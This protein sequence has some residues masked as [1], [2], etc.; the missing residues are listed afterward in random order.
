MRRGLSRMPCSAIPNGARTQVLHDEVAGE[1]PEE[2]EVV[3]RHRVAPARRRARAGGI[4][5][6]KP[7]KPLK[8]RV[9]LLDEVVEGHAD[10]Q[11]DHDR[12]DALGAHREPA[13]ERRRTPSRS[14][15][16][17]TTASHHG[18]PRLMSVPLRA[19]RWRTCSRRCPPPSSGPATPCRRSRRGRSAR[20]R[21][22]RAPAPAPPIWKVKNGVRHPRID[23]HRQRA[24]AHGARRTRRR[25]PLQPAPLARTVRGD[26]P[27]GRAARRRR[28]PARPASAVRPAPAFMAFRH[29]AALTPRLPRMPCGRK[30]STSAMITKREHHAVGRRVGQAELLGHADQQRRRWPRPTTLPMPPTMTTT[31][32]A[33]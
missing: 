11:R 24:P 23:Q 14:R 22:A 21:S 12:V 13:D 7:W 19:R 17:R 30:A 1:R 4:T 8:M 10:G 26:G 18:Q 33:S 29:S 9:V 32:E 15:A 25:D 6:W 3:E 27:R 2:R 5:L 16:R 28:R 31:S 20:A